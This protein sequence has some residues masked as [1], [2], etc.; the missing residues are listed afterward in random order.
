MRSRERGGNRGR[1]Q[2]EGEK[3]KSS[4]SDILIDTIVTIPM[5]DMTIPLELAG[6]SNDSMAIRE[7]IL[8][9]TPIGMPETAASHE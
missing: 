4:C 1:A 5:Y 8:C 7:N 2:G 6:R 9:S 3:E